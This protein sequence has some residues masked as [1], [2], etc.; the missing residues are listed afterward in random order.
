MPS[1]RR[2]SGHRKLT[3]QG[4]Q[5]LRAGSRNQRIEASVDQG[6]LFRQAGEISGASDLLVIEIQRRSH[7]HK[8]YITMQ[9]FRHGDEKASASVKLPPTIDLLGTFR[10][11]GGL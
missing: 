2:R 7:L 4:R 10:N 1:P 6:R 11:G 8:L 3:A 5:P 9:T